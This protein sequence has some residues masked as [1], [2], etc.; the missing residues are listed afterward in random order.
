MLGR[1]D[2]RPEL[3]HPV[4]L[5]QTLLQHPVLAFEPFR[6][7]Q[8]F[9]HKLHLVKLKGFSDIIVGPQ[10]HGLNRRRDGPVAG[11]NDHFRTGFVG[12]DDLDK[13][14]SVELRQAQVHQ[15]YIVP[16]TTQERQGL[17]AVTGGSRLVSQRRQEPGA[18]VTE[19]FVVVND[20]E[21]ELSV[22]PSSPALLCLT[23]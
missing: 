18:Q 16:F 15:G 7:E 20:Q 1:T 19:R 6:P 9:D 10:L 14:E 21:T 5:V 13:L 17:L 12:F 2:N 22:H 8:P 23:L 11:Q 3:L 4:N